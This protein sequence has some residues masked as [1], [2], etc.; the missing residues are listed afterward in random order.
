MKVGGKTEDEKGKGTSHCGKK[1][2][3]ENC[4]NDE[5]LVVLPLLIVMME[6]KSKD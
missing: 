5:I 2:S 3:G 6:L 1:F 4:Q